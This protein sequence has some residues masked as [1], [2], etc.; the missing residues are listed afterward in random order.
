MLTRHSA[1][2]KLSDSYSCELFY[3]ETQY[4]A[5][6]APRVRQCLEKS[7]HIINDICGQVT[8]LIQEVRGLLTPE[9]LKT[10]S[11]LMLECVYTCAQNI[12]WVSQETNNQQLASAKM[13]S[14]DML[15]FLDGRWKSAGK[16]L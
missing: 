15:Q 9:T 5:Q 4:D 3:E 16:L 2:F 13:V 6:T 11:P 10:V 12:L 14:E 7:L 1:L 8:T